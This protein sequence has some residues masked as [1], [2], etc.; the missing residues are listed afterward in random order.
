MAHNKIFSGV[1]TALVTPFLDNNDIDFE[2]FEKILR[3]QKEAKVNGVVVLGTTGESPTLNKDESIE[4]VKKALNFQDDNFHIYLGTGTNCT[5]SSIEKTQN[6]MDI[7]GKNGQKAKG[8]MLV[9]PYY[10]KPTQDGIF[11][12]FSEILENCQK[13]VCIYNVPGR[14]VT[15]IAPKTLVKLFMKYPNALAVKEAS[16]DMNQITEIKLGLQS[17]G[18]NDVELL[19]GDDS[20]F[21]Y[22]LIC[23]VS[24]IISVASHIFPQTFLSLLSA[25]KDN[26]LGAIQ[27]LHLK[28]SPLLNK[29]YS[30]PNPVG[31]KAALSELGLCK[32]HVRAPLVSVNPKEMS[33]FKDFTDEIR[34]EFKEKDLL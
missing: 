27:K 6:Y 21:A 8:A 14:T 23:G 28:M 7:E 3:T 33:L 9:C 20:S 18:R 12:H 16:G 32:T 11:K 25:F 10:N 1:I 13:N 5:R 15:S 22:S 24:G 29:I 4:L 19:S 2:S 26:N 30:L 34:K 17:I 31:I